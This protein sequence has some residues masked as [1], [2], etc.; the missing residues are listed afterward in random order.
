MENVAFFDLELF[1]KTDKKIRQIGAWWDG[2][3]WKG[4]GVHALEQFCGKALYQA[5]HNIFDYD[6][7][8]LEK[9]GASKQFLQS[10][11]IDTL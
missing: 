4:S 9:F 1:G 10:R 5:G 7:P 8:F 6:I 3:A 2:Q 11:F